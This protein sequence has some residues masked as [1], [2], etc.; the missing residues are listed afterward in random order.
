MSLFC[1]RVGESQQLINLQTHYEAAET[2]TYKEQ[3][4]PK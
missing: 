1:C 2:K 3:T 4:Y